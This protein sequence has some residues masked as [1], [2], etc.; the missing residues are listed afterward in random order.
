MLLTERGMNQE[1]A[2]ANFDFFNATSMSRQ[3]D[4]DL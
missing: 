2:T 4:K 1:C 3:A